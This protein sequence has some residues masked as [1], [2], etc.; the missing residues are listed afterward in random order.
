MKSV[1]QEQLENIPPFI[2]ECAINNVAK[3]NIPCWQCSLSITCLTLKAYLKRY[4][5]E[6]QTN[7][8]GDM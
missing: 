5:P 8:I 6:N 4:L 7:P 1:M 3:H 2:K